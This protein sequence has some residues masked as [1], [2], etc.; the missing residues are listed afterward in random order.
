MKPSKIQ[1]KKKIGYRKSQGATRWMRTRYTVEGASFLRQHPTA[2][3]IHP[4][5]NV[6]MHLGLPCYKELEWGL[7][8]GSGMGQHVLTFQWRFCAQQSPWLTPLFSAWLTVHVGVLYNGRNPAG[9]HCNS[10]S[11][12]SDILLLTLWDP[13]WCTRCVVI[14]RPCLRLTAGWSR[15]CEDIKGLLSDS[16]SPGTNLLAVRSKWVFLAR[17]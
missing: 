12:V 8:S 11:G 7:G 6:L 5:W 9:S 13:T 2:A 15:P 3:Q 4:H 10:S 16:L 14:D 1:K 17:E